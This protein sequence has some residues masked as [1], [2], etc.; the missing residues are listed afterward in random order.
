MRRAPT[1][2]MSSGGRLVV[3]AGGDGSGKTTLIDSLYAWLS[4]RF[5]IRGF[6]IGKP[7]WSMTTV[8]VRGLLKVGRLL[9]LWP[10]SLQNEDDPDQVGFAGY[11]SLIRT[12][13]TARDRWLHYT[14]ARRFASNGGL[15]ICDRFPLPGTITMDGPQVA[16]MTV[17]HEPTWFLKRL[18]K[19]EAGFYERILAPDLLVVLKLDPDIAV[20]RK[21]DEDPVSVRARTAKVWKAEWEK[22]PARII[23][24]SQSKEAVLA[25]LKNL[26]WSQL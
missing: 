15:A 21:T 22:T 14:R 7:P 16:R 26:L 4:G 23:D 8:A 17:G 3:V 6:H 25:E 11:P 9:G 13:C 2:Q 5:E 19:L 10:F 20:R 24:A 18:A 1:M 12:V